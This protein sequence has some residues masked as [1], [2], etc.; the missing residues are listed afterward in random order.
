M[1][2]LGAMYVT[3][4]SYLGRGSQA[5]EWLASLG[6]APTAAT[7]GG[8]LLLVAYSQQVLN[9]GDSAV[10]ASDLAERALDGGM[11]LE[12]VGPASLEIPSAAYALISVAS[13]RLRSGRSPPQPMRHGDPDRHPGTR[14]LSSS[15]GCS[16]IAAA[17]CRRR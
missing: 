17:A 9:S 3:T 12:D 6:A 13:T 11:L 15:A 1:L 5:R 8:R 4:S 10:A 14:W 2:R 7:P 16:P